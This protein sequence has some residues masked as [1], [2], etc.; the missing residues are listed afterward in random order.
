M[1]AKIDL[2]TNSD[3][4]EFCFA[5]SKVN[6]DVIIRTKNGKY[7]VNAKSIMGCLLAAAEWEGDTWVETEGDTYTHFEKWINTAAG[8]ANFIHD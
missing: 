5:A 7:K 1:V 2:I 6:G 3:I 8:D 4:N